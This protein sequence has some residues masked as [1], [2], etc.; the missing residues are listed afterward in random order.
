MVPASIFDII[1]AFGPLHCS[2]R[3]GAQVTR[4]R[5]GCMGNILRRGIPFFKPEQPFYTYSIDLLIL[6]EGAVTSFFLATTRRAWPNVH[7]GSIYYKAK[8]PLRHAPRS[9]ALVAIQ[10][11]PRLYERKCG[12]S[13]D[14]ENTFGGSLQLHNSST[15]GLGQLARAQVRRASTPR[16]AMG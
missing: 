9:C 16:G 8:R 3:A 10:I 2:Q 4:F 1:D 7:I 12:A 5:R 11:K 14:E 13:R 15:S 6:Q